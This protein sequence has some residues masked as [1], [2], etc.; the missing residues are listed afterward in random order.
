LKLRR[1]GGGQSLVFPKDLSSQ[2]RSDVISGGN[3]HGEPIAFTLDFLAI[4]LCGVAG[5]PSAAWNAW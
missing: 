1:L 5:F 3:F 2:W 4:A